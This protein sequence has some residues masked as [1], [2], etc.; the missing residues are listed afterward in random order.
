MKLGQVVLA[1]LAAASVLLASWWQNQLGDE[2][3]M[4][5]RLDAGPDYYMTDFILHVTDAEGVP[6]YRLAANHFAHLGADDTGELQEPT[7]SLHLTEEPPWLMRAASGWIGPQG[8]ELF[9]LG[10]VTMQ[11]A[12]DDRQAPIMIVSDDL[13]IRPGDRV[14]STESTVVATSGN[15]RLHGVG[16]FADLAHERMQLLANVRGRYAP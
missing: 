16:M 13:R 2:S 12:G 7:F 3:A 10:G 6:V 5:L 11:R 15:H 14:A 4:S 9:L 8:A 1:I